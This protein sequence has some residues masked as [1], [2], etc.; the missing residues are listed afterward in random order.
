MNILLV[1]DSFPP[2]I[3]SASHLMLELAQELYK[4]GHVVT[5]IT[6]WPEY[7]LDQ[8]STKNHFKEKEVENG[9][10]VLRVRTLPHHN[11]N[12]IVRGLSQ[13][14]MPLQFLIK[15]YKHKIRPD[16]AIIYSPPLPLALVGSWLRK[17]GVRTLLNI[18]DLFPQNAIDLNILRSPLQIKFFQAL[19]RFAYATSDVVTVHSEGNR[20]MVLK[21]HPAL[22]QKIS[23]L[24]NWVDIEHHTDGPSST[25]FRQKW[26][27]KHKHIA[28][29]AG[30]IGPSQYLELILE[31]AH[32]LRE[33][34]ELLFLIVGD[35][36]EKG[37]LQKMASDMQLPNVQ[38]EG[39]V[40]REAYPDLLRI[41]SIGLVC[42]SPQNKTPVVPGK[43]LGHMAA[44][45]PI[46]A[47]LHSASDAHSLIAQ[48][49]CGVSAHSGDLNACVD[50]M[51]YLIADEPN[52][53]KIGLSGKRFAQANFSKEVCVDQIEQLIT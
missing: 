26:S 20:T 53:Y 32:Q 19:E 35:G 38:F 29:F 14:I 4:R 27:L 36:K 21:Q 13:L 52:F 46:A 34:R 31:I 2:E 28:I 44:G 51:R 43:I 49:H 18:Q 6:T 25:D 50:A 7:N 12:Y 48:A 10:V 3:R 30:V 39:F 41:C 11:V 24:H 40:S 5:V 22:S 47:F 9:I 16:A 42:L 37:R 17:S 45:L 8:A 15:L 33:Q 23:L 1:T